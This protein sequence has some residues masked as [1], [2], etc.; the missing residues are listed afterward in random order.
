MQCFSLSVRVRKDGLLT[1]WSARSNVAL[2]D[3]NAGVVTG[4]RQAST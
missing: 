4:L 1:I 3:Q 2:A